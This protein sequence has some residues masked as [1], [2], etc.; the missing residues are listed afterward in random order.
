M[1]RSWQKFDE[2]QRNWAAREKV[3]ED[4][5]GCYKADALF[6]NTVMEE[7]SELKTKL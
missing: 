2:L 7:N 1:Q 4:K 5:V 6:A 3:L